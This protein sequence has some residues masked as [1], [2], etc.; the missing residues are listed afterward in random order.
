MAIWTVK[1]LYQ[2]SCEQHEYFTHEDYD[3]PIK[4]VDGFRSCEYQ[5]ETSDE[6]I[7]E[8][9]FTHVP[10]GDG[11]KDSINL[12]SCSTGNIESSELIEMFDG[13]CW[14]EIEFP[15]DMDEDEQER[16]REVINEGGSYALEHEGND[17]SLDETAVWVWGPLEISDD[18]GE[19]VRI[20]CADEEG[21]VIDFIEQQALS[22]LRF[23]YQLLIAACS[24]RV[25]YLRL[26]D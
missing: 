11:L 7:P 9:E 23:D 16:L 10:G 20:I 22:I 8:F 17:W 13:G 15:D 26:L 19:V 1:A 21:N 2:K 4:V 3:Q 25:I 5:I 24:F 14:G 12:N 18:Q 6:N